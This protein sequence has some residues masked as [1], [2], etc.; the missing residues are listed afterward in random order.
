MGEIRAK[1]DVENEADHVRYAQRKI[2]QETI[3]HAKLDVLVNTGAV[4]VLP[5]QEVVE[6]LGLQKIDRAIVTLANDQKIELDIAGTLSLS[7]CGRSMKTDCLVGP[8]SCEPL[9]GQGVLERLDLVIDPLK[10]TLTPR[11]ESPYLPSLKLKLLG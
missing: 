5:P 8:P 7:V 9:I 3:R 2:A 11:P 6:V 10:R 1:V 4:M